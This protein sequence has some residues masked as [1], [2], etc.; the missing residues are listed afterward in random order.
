MKGG[1]R[2]EGGCEANENIFGKEK[3]GKARSVVVIEDVEVFRVIGCRSCQ[4][5]KVGRVTRSGYS[6]GRI[7]PGTCRALGF[8]LLAVRDWT[9]PLPRY[10]VQNKLLR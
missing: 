9:Q 8:F 6:S 1:Y 5:G 10:S 3:S 4:S 2:G 7:K